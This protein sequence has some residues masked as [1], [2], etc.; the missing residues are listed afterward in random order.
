MEDI[1]YLFFIANMPSSRKVLLAMSEA[2]IS[3][4]GSK[5]SAVQTELVTKTVTANESW[6]V[7]D[8]EGNISVRIFG[9]GGGGSYG[10]AGSEWN[11]FGG[12]GGPWGGG[13]YGIYYAGI[14]GIYGGNG[15]QGIRGSAEN[16]TNTIGNNSVPYELQGAGFSGRTLLSNGTWMYGQGGGGGY[17]GNGSDGDKIINR[18]TVS[19][20]FGGGGGGYGG[21][22]GAGSYYGGGGGG[23]YGGDGGD[24]RGGG[25]GGGGYGRGGGYDGVTG[26][27]GGGGSESG[28]GGSGICILQYYEIS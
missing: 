6:T 14:G 10:G 3:R 27:F 21:N 11:S 24:S 4:R 19:S 12:N 26:E 13:G 23:G 2:I 9:G 28:N 17:G 18:N 8:H 20:G 22:G 25:G 7:P 16:G 15:S 1:H 5:E